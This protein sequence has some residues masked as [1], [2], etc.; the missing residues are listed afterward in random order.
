[1]SSAGLD[2][3]VCRVIMGMQRFWNIFTGCLRAVPAIVFDEDA[4][5]VPKELPTPKRLHIS[6]PAPTGE[7]AVH[8]AHAA[9]RSLA[10]LL[11]AVGDVANLDDLHGFPELDSCMPEPGTCRLHAI[12]S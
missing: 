12:A 10:G 7:D 3:I 8:E 6:V 1:M 11:N 2:V 4:G 9:L 5:V